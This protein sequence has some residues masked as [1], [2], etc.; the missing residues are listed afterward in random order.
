MTARAVPTEHYE[1]RELV[2]W[3][4]LTFPGVLLMAIP[5]ALH[6]NPKPPGR[7][8]AEGVL[9]GVP[10]L[11][12]PAWRLWI[13]MKRTKGGVVSG[14]QKKII[15]ALRDAGYEVLI[16]RGFA[17]AQEQISEHVKKS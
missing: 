11:F 4:R 17:D 16:C 2:R 8:K 10:D 3:F 6:L 7:L 14:E 9:A 13:E 15:S 12:V 5:S 1:Q